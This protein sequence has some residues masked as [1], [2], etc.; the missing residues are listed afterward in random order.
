MKRKIIFISDFFSDHFVGGAALNDEE[1]VS[2][3][4]KEFEVVKIKSRYTYSGFI[5]ENKNNFF[6]ISNF[7]ELPQNV[8]QSLKSC[9][10]AIYAHDYKF[11]KHTNPAVYEN[12]KVPEED[13][14]SLDFYKQSKK[15]ICQSKLQKE[16]YDLNLNFQD[17][18]I[19][20]SGNLWSSK[21][22]ELMK[23][24]KEEKKENSSA[25]MSSPYPQKGTQ[26]AIDFCK[27][28]KKRANV[29]SSDNYE[30]F[31]K[32]MSSNS[33]FIFF[34]TTP[35]TLS[36]TCVEAKLMGIKVITNKLTGVFHEPWFQ[37]S[38]EEVNEYLLNKKNTF[39]KFIKTII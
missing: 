14:I 34:P 23:K 30:F 35:E 38:S 25:I 8:V 18:T 31:L 15:I 6:I 29:I 20:F 11:V 27:E 3:L 16:I 5:E 26:K 37:K 21:H 39:C 9:N 2:L 12:F 24:L 17:K 32:K 1:A 36:R 4:S 19:N 10:Y 7:F 22:L 13:L 28:N 33:E